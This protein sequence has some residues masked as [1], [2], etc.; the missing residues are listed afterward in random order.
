VSALNPFAILG[1]I[2]TT[3]LPAPLIVRIND[4]LDRVRGLLAG[5]YLRLVIYGAA[6]VVYLTTHILQTLNIGHLPA[7]NLDAAI[8]IVTVAAGLLTEYLRTKVSSA[9]TVAAI[10]A[11]PPT[12]AGPINAAAAAGVDPALIGAAI[13]KAPDAPA[14]VEVAPEVV[15]ATPAPDPAADEPEVDPSTI[16]DGGDAA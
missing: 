12:A 13:V 11:S 6:V 14:D 3:I 10:V 8:A 9:A 4:L 2:L 1:T 5:E 15:A 16:A 7:V